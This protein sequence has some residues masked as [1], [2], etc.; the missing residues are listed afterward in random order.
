MADEGAR[1][2]A[3]DALLFVPLLASTIA[4]CWEVGWFLPI[5]GFKY[6]SLSEHVLAA[7]QALP[8]ALLLTIGF[9]V[10][11]LALSRAKLGSKTPRNK[12]FV[13]VIFVLVAVIG[14]AV[15]TYLRPLRTPPIFATAGALALLLLVANA[16]WWQRSPTNGVGALATLGTVIVLTLF[17]S[18][19][20]C[21]QTISAGQLATVVSKSGQFKAIVLMAGDHALLFYDPNSDNVTY[22]RSDEV[23]KIEWQR[24]FGLKIW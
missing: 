18:I 14:A 22:L 23:Q 7:A 12:V 20:G 5:G 2:G 19:D 16:L 10:L 13:F 15:G 3:K 4:L 21:L 17:A 8:L 11:I 1:L 9:G 24:R 6:F